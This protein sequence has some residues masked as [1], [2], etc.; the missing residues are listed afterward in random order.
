[1]AMRPPATRV[2]LKAYPT[3]E[4]VERAKQAANSIRQAVRYLPEGLAS[5]QARYD[6]YKA[7]LQR[8]GK[9]DLA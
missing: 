1:M 2:M 4:I 5:A 6:V 9:G 3:R 7:E 8:R